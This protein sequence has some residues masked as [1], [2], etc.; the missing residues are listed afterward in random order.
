[1]KM[2]GSRDSERDYRPPKTSDSPSDALSE[3]LE[4]LTPSDSKIEQDEMTF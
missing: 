4:G 3:T 1:M 2:L